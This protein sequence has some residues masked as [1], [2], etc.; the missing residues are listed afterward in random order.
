MQRILLS[1]VAL[2][3]AAPAFA[4]GVDLSGQHVTLLFRDGTYAEI[5]YTNW[6][7]T[8]TG[9]DQFGTGSGNVYG[10]Y[11]FVNGGFKTDLSDK[12]SVALILDQPWG[13][14]VNYPAGNFAYAGTTAQSET[15]ELTGLVRY[16]LNGNWSLHGG[17]RAAT[18]GADVTLAGLAFG[19][20][21]YVWN[22]EHEWGLGYVV[23]GAYEIPEIAL[24]VALTYGSEI[25]Y[26]LDST[27]TVPGLGTARSTTDVTMPR[28][29]NLDFQTGLNSTT[30][31]FGSVRW[32]NW[33]SWTIAPELLDDISGA[34]LADEDSDT[35]RYKIGLGRQLTENFAAAFEVGYLTAENEVQ[36]ALQP[37]DGYAS[38]GLGG[39]Y[40]FDS[41]LAIT[42]GAAY[43]WLGD[44]DVSENNVASRF[45]DN[46]AVGLSVNIGYTF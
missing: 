23:G 18:F 45:T 43:F 21:G 35:F 32:V 5:G 29:V 42:A 15:V 17:L 44:T 33:A 11:P 46:T 31:L 36:G 39:T 7:P 16:K 40:T 22:G 6:N 10:D 9:S 30:L 14:N 28:S 19:N 26:S 27:E 34:A 20:L 38:V 4:D 37:Y 25:D 3:G 12:W 41:G 2:L 8:I 24:R 13:V 1:T